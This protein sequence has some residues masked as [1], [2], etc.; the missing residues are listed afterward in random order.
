M[1]RDHNAQQECFFRAIRDR[2]IACYEDIEY[3]LSKGATIS[4]TRFV[5]TE[6]ESLLPLHQAIIV[7]DLN[8]TDA[9]LEAGAGVNGMG[10]RGDTPLHLLFRC[11][12][13]DHQNG[14][15]PEPSVDMALKI[16]KLLRKS[17][18]LANTASTGT[19]ETALMLAV[20]ID[21]RLVNELLS[22]EARV[23]ARSSRSETP[24]GITCYHE[25][26]SLD[27]I[28][29][30]VSAGAKVNS[31]SMGLGKTP[32]HLIAGNRGS[33]E[34][35][36]RQILLYLLDRG[37]D[38]N[39][40][41]KEGRTPLHCAALNNRLECVSLLKQFGAKNSVDHGGR[42]PLTLFE[43][44]EGVS[45]EVYEAGRNKLEACLNDGVS[46]LKSLSA[47]VVRKHI[48]PKETI[49]EGIDRL[50]FPKLLKN[51]IKL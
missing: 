12:Q 23:N 21:V 1:L 30:L 16:V 18:A 50:N 32:L 7:H 13:R 22:M 41:D 51:V 47:L 38:P 39:I 17:G 8:A 35:S 19:A 46:S 48:F 20:T 3:Y 40:K 10:P 33:E 26:P 31:K 11:L 44:T 34:V 43:Q 4:G 6:Y 42:T 5:A 25:R 29:A 49:D 2:K 36:I 27:I 28:K 45:D 9:L 15:I 24:L 37:A 14:E